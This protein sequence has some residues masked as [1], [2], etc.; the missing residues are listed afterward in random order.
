MTKA[1]LLALAECQAARCRFINRCKIY[2]GRRCSRLGG[3]KIPRIR[4]YKPLVRYFDEPV[5]CYKQ[6]WA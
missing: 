3:K 4:P 5:A 1:E 2:W 6:P